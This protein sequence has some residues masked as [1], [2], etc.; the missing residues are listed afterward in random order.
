MSYS[1]RYTIKNAIIPEDE[2]GAALAAVNALFTNE[3]RFAWLDGGTRNHPDLKTAI[4]EWGF[5]V[6]AHN[7]PGTGEVLEITNFQ[8]GK[9]G[10]E[11]ALL[12]RLAPFIGPN[13][14]FECAG[15]DGDLWRYIFRYGYLVTQK[16]RIVYE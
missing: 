10:E 16:G 13:A 4:E 9:S 11:K 2:W 8:W 15:E 12:A 7:S 6:E 14:I 5:E 3:K 1:V